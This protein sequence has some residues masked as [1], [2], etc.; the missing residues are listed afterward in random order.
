MVFQ[1]AIG[2]KISYL[3]TLIAMMVISLGI[4]FSLG[5]ILTLVVLGCMPIIGW[6]WFKNASFKLSAKK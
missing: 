1:Q 4:A 6:A 2:E 5:W 3:I